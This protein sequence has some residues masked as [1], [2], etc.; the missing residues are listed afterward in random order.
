MILEK[1]LHRLLSCDVSGD[2]FLPPHRIHS[3]WDRFLQRMSEWHV[4]EST[5]HIISYPEDYC[6][7]VDV[8][9]GESEASR[10]FA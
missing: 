8:K 6:E 7:Y 1:T 4:D 3:S 5:A 9:N 10:S 2:G